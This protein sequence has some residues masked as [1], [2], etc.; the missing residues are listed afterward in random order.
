MMTAVAVEKAA[1]CLANGESERVQPVA[2]RI[3]AKAKCTAAARNRGLSPAF[4]TQFLCRFCMEGYETERDA[5]SN[6]NPACTRI[7]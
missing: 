2:R 1:V 7:I 6:G 5:L 4:V 3:R